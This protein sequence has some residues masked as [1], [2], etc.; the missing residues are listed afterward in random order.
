MRIP[1]AERAVSDWI[2]Y[3]G[4]FNQH[5]QDVVPRYDNGDGIN[6]HHENEG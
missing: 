1:R 3:V 4:V 2:C 5:F 6:Y